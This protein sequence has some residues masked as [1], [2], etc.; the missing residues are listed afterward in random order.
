MELPPKALYALID[1]KKE[2]LSRVAVEEVEPAQT[3]GRDKGVP[4]PTFR[5]RH[6]RSSGAYQRGCQG[7]KFWT[8]VH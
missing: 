1:I 7:H 3:K 8:P 5:Q 6:A 4:A 2:L